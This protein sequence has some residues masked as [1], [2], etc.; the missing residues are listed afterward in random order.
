MRRRVFV[1]TLWYGAVLHQGR[2]GALNSADAYIIRDNAYEQVLSALSSENIIDYGV[3]Q[4]LDKTLVLTPQIRIK[5]SSAP[6][7]SR[8]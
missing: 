1:R 5:N 7:I 6:R 4:S 3:L 2:G 8:T